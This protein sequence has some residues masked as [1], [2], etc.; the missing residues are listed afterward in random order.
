MCKLRIKTN[1]KRFSEENFRLEG[2]RELKLELGLPGKLLILSMMSLTIDPSWSQSIL[3]SANTAGLSTKWCLYI[4]TSCWNK[5]G[6][7]YMQHSDTLDY[8]I[9]GKIKP[10]IHID[11]WYIYSI[12][13]FLN[14]SSLMFY[15]YLILK[16]F[17]S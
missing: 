3:L 4:S 17:S 7:A 15:Q 8:C 16:Y 5:I 13:T 12:I 1:L 9:F 2:Q 11:Y 14:S 6:L 10:Q